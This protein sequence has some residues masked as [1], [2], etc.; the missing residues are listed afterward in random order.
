MH[1]WDEATVNLHENSYNY[2]PKSS[3]DSEY[4]PGVYVGASPMVGKFPKEF[5]P[6][7]LRIFRKHSTQYSLRK[8]P[9]KSEKDQNM[10]Q[11][12]TN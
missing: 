9:G 12:A 8:F 6:L 11:Q 10:Y 5:N 3:V 4:S 7:A 1:T 2:C